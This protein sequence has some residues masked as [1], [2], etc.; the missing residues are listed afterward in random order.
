MFGL[1]Y[2]FHCLVRDISD[3][4]MPIPNTRTYTSILMHALQ[5]TYSFTGN[6][7]VHMGRKAIRS[8]GALE[9]F[10]EHFIIKK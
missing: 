5:F 4:C 3:L 1:E 2:S 6:Y 9:T 10:R 7:F 8:K